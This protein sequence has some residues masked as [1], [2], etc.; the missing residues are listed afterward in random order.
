MYSKSPYFLSRSADDL[1]SVLE[2]S[3]K[4]LN[5]GIMKTSPCVC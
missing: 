5:K 4:V 2:S 3:K 1:V